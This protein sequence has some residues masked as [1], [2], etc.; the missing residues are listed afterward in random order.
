[1]F[2]EFVIVTLLFT[3]FGSLG[4]FQGFKLPSGVI[5]L[6]QHSFAPIYLLAAVM[7]RYITLLYV[8]AQQYNYI[9]RYSI[10]YSCV[11]NQLRKEIRR[12]I[13]LYY[14]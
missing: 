5:S 14:L 7:A 10:L 1:M 4:M 12:N 8:L 9:Y 11:L 13:H 2:T 3:V 6:A